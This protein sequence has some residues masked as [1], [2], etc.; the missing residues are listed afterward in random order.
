MA[1]TKKKSAPAPFTL[2]DT[3]RSLLKVRHAEYSAQLAATHRAYA[4]LN[5]L[6]LAI[7][8][9]GAQLDMRSGEPVL[10]PAA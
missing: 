8:G 7:G 9:E 5:D 1:K 10:T 2:T 4:M 6:V 3:Q